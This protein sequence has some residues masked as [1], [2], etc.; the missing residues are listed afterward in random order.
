[1]FG[2]FKDVIKVG[3]SKFVIIIF[4]IIT[5]IIIAREFGPEKNGVIAS[6][7]VFPSLFMSVGSLGIRQ[8]TTYFLGKKIFN[9][10]EIKTAVSQIWLISSV[11]SIIFCFLLMSFLSKSGDNLILLL[12]AI[13][14]IPFSLFNT[15]NSGIF[16]GKNQI[17]DFNKINWIPSLLIFIFTVILVLVFR[18]DLKGYFIALISGPLFISIFLLFKNKFFEILF[19]KFNWQVIKSM[20]KLGSIYAI[21]LMFISLNARLDI[22]LLEIWSTDFETGIYAKG[23][24][25]GNYILQIPWMLNVIIFS[26][27]SIA[28][29]DKLFSK[30]ITQLLRVS[31]L[32]ILCFSVLLFLFSDFIIVLMFGEDFIGSSI[33]L[34]YLLI[35]VLFLSLFKILNQ[36]LAGKGKPW[37]SMK[38][39]IPGL[40][41]NILLNYFLIPA[42]GAKG[43]SLASSISYT[44]AIL[45]FLHFYSKEVNISI[46]N[47]IRYKV[48]DFK[49]LLKIFKKI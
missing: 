47:I 39:M 31:F 23:Y 48:S 5:S 32:L 44:F 43:A 49:P 25:V 1:M 30:K 24:S 17:N 2:F 41:V 15:Y 21:A 38:A 35:G 29:N 4:G 42:Y 36:D 3:I 9:E 28:K 33:V 27:S 22:I 45:L 7:L 20:L 40:I 10:I 19:L 13:A 8:C 14:P 11:T 37:V 12:L 46:K 34:K 18:L 16:L 26:R 6:L